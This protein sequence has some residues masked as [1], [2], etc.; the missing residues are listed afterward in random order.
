MMNSM[1]QRSRFLFAALAVSSL[2]SLGA[3]AQ[4]SQDGW[5]S[6]FNGTNLDGWT[7]KIA[8]HPLGE[9]Y[10][11]TFRI[12]DGI[13]KVSYDDYDKFDQQYGHL[14]TNIAYSHYLF[15][16]EYR[17][18]GTMMP[19]APK[20]VNLNSGIMI[21]AQSPQSMRMD[22]GFPSSL[23]MQFLADEGKGPRSTANL[24]T[25]GT[26]VEIDGKLVTQHI[27]KSTAP[28]FPADEWVK[29]EIEVH[30]NEEVI[31]RVNGVEV[32]R[33]QRPQLDPN[34][35]NAPATDLL[36][37]GAPLMLSYGHIAL[38]AE[39]QPVWFRNIQLKSLEK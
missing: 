20:Y 23:E 4:E 8:K 5:I 29:M 21:H 26:N 11:N 22:Q 12:E 37:A 36:K 2:M 6:L 14:F 33:Y 19:D 15:R 16:V 24:C 1:I 28:T 31:H 38:Q 30:G 9:N 25:P 3:A 27:V 39:G 18:T 17:F 32:L 13:L 10:A 34:D 7:I 35:N